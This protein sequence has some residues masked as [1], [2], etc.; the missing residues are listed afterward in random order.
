M[1]AAISEFFL[2]SIIGCNDEAENQDG[3]HVN[4][5][6][7]SLQRRNAAD[8]S[9]PLIASSL[10]TFTSLEPSLTL[11]ESGSTLIPWLPFLTTQ[12]QSLL[13]RGPSCLV[14]D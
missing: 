3:I 4:L 10:N 13:E 14:N 6:T 7:S 9:K 1:A 12:E 11:G 2:V 5:S 8:L